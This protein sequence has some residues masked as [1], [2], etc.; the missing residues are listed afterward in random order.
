MWWFCSKERG[1]HSGTVVSTDD[2]LQEGS[3]FKQLGSYH[4]E[5][6][7]SPHVCLSTPMSSHSPKTCRLD[8]LEIACSC[9]CESEPFVFACYLVL[10]LWAWIVGGCWCFLINVVNIDI[11]LMCSVTCDICCTSVRPGRRITRGSLWRFLRSSDVFLFSI[12]FCKLWF[13]NTGFTNTCWWLIC[14]PCDMLA[15]SPGCAPPLIQCQLGL[16]PVSPKYKW[17]G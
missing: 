5:F 8:W 2:S 17:Y 10:M 11:L 7:C 3:G 12:F 15:T 6:A 16:A 13:V 4:V 9:Q 1:W 14:L